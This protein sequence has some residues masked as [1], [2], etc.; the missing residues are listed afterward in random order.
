MPAKPLWLLRLPQIIEALES[1]VAPVVDRESVERLFGVSRRR[2]IQLLHRFGGYQAGKTFLVD[3]QD[4][5][6]QLRAIRDSE[7]FSREA[8]RRERVVRELDEISRLQ[9]ARAVK[10]K[11]ARDEA[12]KA[13]GLPQGVRVEPGRLVVEFEGLE[14]LLTRLFK[15][16]Q[17]ALQDFAVFEQAIVG[18]ERAASH[19]EEEAG[20]QVKR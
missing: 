4:L 11:V 13:R 15:L 16:S 2:A 9:K 18:A 3:R 17:S 14:E 19:E 10:I 12:A 7:V 20:G 5:V 6:A 1:I 8:K